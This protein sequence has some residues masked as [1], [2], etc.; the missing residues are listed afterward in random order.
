MKENEKKKEID[1]KIYSQC[2]YE[3]KISGKWIKVNY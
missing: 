3:I 2:T 1:G